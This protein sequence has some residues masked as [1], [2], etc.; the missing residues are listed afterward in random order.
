MGKTLSARSS[1]YKGSQ[2]GSWKERF[3]GVRESTEDTPI[4][5]EGGEGSFILRSGHLTS[6]EVLPQPG[7]VERN[8]SCLSLRRHQCIVDSPTSSESCPTG[9]T[10]QGALVTTAKRTTGSTVPTTGPVC[11]RCRDDQIV[12]GERPDEV[13]GRCRSLHSVRGDCLRQ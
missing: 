10:Q 11:P 7:L 8:T 13:S 9:R 3:L 5:K 1:K 6:S 2:R 4:P 12:H